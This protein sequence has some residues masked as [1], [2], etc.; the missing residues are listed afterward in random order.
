M[1]K[2]TER[3]NKTLPPYLIILG[4]FVPHRDIVLLAPVWDFASTLPRAM[5]GGDALPETKEA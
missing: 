3:R 2:I 5:P 4:V 1:L